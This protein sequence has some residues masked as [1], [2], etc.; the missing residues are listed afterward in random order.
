MV[1]VWDRV[2]SYI[3]DPKTQSD[4]VRIMAARVGIS[5]EAYLPLLKGTKLVTLAEARKILVKA[6]GF[7]S[8]YGSCKIAD[9]F[10]VA[11]AVYKTPQDV[12]SYIDASLTNAK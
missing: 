3:N 2:V 7:G 10:N 12:A 9:A 8:L 5:P 1:K 11:N 4:A 6:E